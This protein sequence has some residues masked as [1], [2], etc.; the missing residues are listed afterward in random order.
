MTRGDAHTRRS[1]GD[2]MRRAVRTALERRRPGA[3][4]AG[5]GGQAVGSNG[6]KRDACPPREPTLAAA[7]LGAMRC[8]PNTRSENGGEVVGGIR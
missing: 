8:P 1:G 2:A 5:G 6:G 7:L 3:R 4:R